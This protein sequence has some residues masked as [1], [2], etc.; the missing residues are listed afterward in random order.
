MGFLA[1]GAAVGCCHAAGTAEIAIF[2]TRTDGT[3]C[4]SHLQR[5][6]EGDVREKVFRED[7]LGRLSILFLET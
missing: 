4:G 1:G 2:G 7:V 3:R 5:R 6:V